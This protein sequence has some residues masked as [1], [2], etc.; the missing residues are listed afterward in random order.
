MNKG[1]RVSKKSKK[2]A[3]T[4]KKYLGRTAAAEYIGVNKD[5]LINWEERGIIAPIR[6]GA[7]RDRR[8]TEAMLLEAFD[9][10]GKDIDTINTLNTKEKLGAF[11]WK[12]ADIL[13]DR[14]E[15]AK[16]QDYIYPLLFFKRISDVGGGL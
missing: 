8:Y 1:K 15:P 2:S 6:M 9:M 3:A 11:L 16:Y 10:A 7:R 13:R 4:K 5:T 14:V 12:A